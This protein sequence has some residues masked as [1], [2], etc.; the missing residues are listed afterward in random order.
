[1]IDPYRLLPT[2]ALV[3]R[4]VNAHEE[5][6]PYDRLNYAAARAVV[7]Q[8]RSN[9]RYDHIRVKVD[10]VNGIFKTS[11]KDTFGVA[12]CIHEQVVRV[13]Q[14]LAKG[15]TSLVAEIARYESRAGVFR[16][17]YSFATK[18]C[19]CHEPELFPIYDQ[20]V[21]KSLCQYRMSPGFDFFTKKGLKSYQT[22]HHVLMAFRDVYGIRRIGGA[23]I[24]RF[25]WAMGKYGQSPHLQRVFRICS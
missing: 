23:K 20:F 17:N 15:D 16:T 13:D 2:P 11:I 19:H 18:Y 22:F 7:D 24:D 21:V 12:R 8:F 9:R 5:E 3:T 4:V 10:V 14:R 25:L 1:M 6:F